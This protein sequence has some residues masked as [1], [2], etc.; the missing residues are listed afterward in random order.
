MS[1]HDAGPLFAVA[2]EAYDKLMGRY[3]P[4]LSVVFADAAQVDPGLRAL[5]VGCGPGGLTTELVRRL[6]REGLAAIDP[7][8]SFV[9]ACRERHPGVDVRS[10]AAEDLPW[11]DDEFDVTLGSLI[12]GFLSDPGGAAQEMR[13]V[14]RPGGRVGLCFWEFERMPLLSTFWR[15]VSEIDP[16]AVGESDR[17]GRRQ[18]QLAGLLEASGLEDVT[19]SS[20][21]ATAEYADPDDWWS[22]FTGGAGPVGA[23]YL[24]MTE[25]ERRRVRHRSF[26][27][28]GR[29]R[30]SFSLEAYTWCAVGSVPC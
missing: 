14:T 30:A 22:S 6:G 15:A 21:R 1:E 23:Q 28:L 8:P 4:T 11:P 29:P 17:F 3:L 5:D 13:R 26:E 18:G 7:S 2:A 19:E 10:G 12:A 24:R 9:A 25:D 27:L 16:A 20:L